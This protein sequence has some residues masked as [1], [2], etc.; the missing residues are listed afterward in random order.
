VEGGDVGFTV[1]LGVG[2]GVDGL[3]VGLVVGG[4]VGLVVGL[5]VGGDVGLVVGLGVGGGVGLLQELHVAAT[6]ETEIPPAGGAGVEK[7]IEIPAP[8]VAPDWML[9]PKLVI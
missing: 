4:V 2:A 8:N 3:G 5:V 6:L 9:P 1:G 7:V